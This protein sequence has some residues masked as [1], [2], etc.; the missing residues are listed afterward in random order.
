MREQMPYGRAGRPGCLVEV[1][2]AFLC[3]DQYCQGGDGLGNRSEADAARG[4]SPV[5]TLPSRGHHSRRGE[6]DRPALDLA[7]RLHAA[8]ILAP[9][10]GTPQI[11]GHS[12]YEAIMGYCRAV[13]VGKHVHVAGTAP[14]QPDGSPPP[15]DAY[16]QTQALLRDHQ[17]C[18][19]AGR[20]RPRAR[21]AH[22]VYVTDPAHFDGI[23]AG[24]RRGLPR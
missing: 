6:R 7:E 10:H 1:D 17:P 4:V 21:R 3:G 23:A 22:A 18:A 13:V 8:A 5:S 12:P 20:V 9:P 11:S 19:G 15:E 2:D 16:E 14:I 24:A